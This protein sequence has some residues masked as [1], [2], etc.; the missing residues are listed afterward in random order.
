[1][2]TNFNNAGVAQV[3]ARILSL[4]SVAR[5]EETNY[6]RYNFVQWMLENFSLSLQQ[7]EQLEALDAYFLDDLAEAVANSWNSGELILFS[8]DKP[9]DDKDP[10]PKDILLGNNTVQHY[11]IDQASEQ[12]NT[13]VSI[14]IRYRS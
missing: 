8:K 5:N 14:Q 6:L 13:Q 12:Q 9:D 1:M 3:Q 2:K 7:Q 4:S 10:S 11:S